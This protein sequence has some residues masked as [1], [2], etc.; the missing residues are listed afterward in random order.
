LYTF[1]DPP[2]TGKAEIV[3]GP[4]GFTV[5]Y[6]RRSYDRGSGQTTVW[7]RMPRDVE[8]FAGLKAVVVFV[9]DVQDDVL[10]L[11]LSAV[12][13]RSGAGQVVVVDGQGGQAPTDVALGV[14]DD[15]YVEVADL[16]EDTEV[17]LYP[18]ESDFDE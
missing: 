17:L 2:D 8:V 15:A 3:G 9:T 11:P 1:A 13:G 7:V 14:S 5:H 10:T 6:D 4:S 12:R 18:L 16:P